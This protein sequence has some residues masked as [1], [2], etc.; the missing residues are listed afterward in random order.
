MSDDIKTYVWIRN[1]EVLN[2]IQWDGNADPSTGGIDIPSGDVIVELLPG[3][4]PCPGYPASQDPDGRWLYSTPPA[5]ALSPEEILS[6]NTLA[7]NTLLE[8][9]TSAIAPLQDA[10]DLGIAT[11][12]EQSLLTAW[13]QFRVAVN[14]ID[15]TAASPEWPAPPAPLS[16]AVGSATA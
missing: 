13:K 10:V 8:K 6:R 12:G 2:I 16:Y 11:V 7:R 15:L 3:D 1:N 9:A 5:P 4:L 14:R